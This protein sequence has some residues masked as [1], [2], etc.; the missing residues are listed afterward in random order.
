MTPPATLR[1]KA[2]FFAFRCVA[3]ALS[4]LPAPTAAALC[5]GL[6]AAVCALPPKWTRRD[7]ARK[8]LT[9]AFPDLSP[10]E[11]DD[12]VRAMWTHLFRLVTEMATFS[13][14]FRRSNMPDVLAFRNRDE[15]TRA[16]NSGRPV[17]M[18]SG[19]FGNWEASA[20]A[21]EAFGI[22]LS[23]VA[24]DLDNPLIHGWFAERRRAGGGRLISK[25]GG[26]GEVTEVLA[27]RGIVGLLGDQDAGSRGL[28][29]PFFGKD[30]STFKSI[31][32]LAI[33]YD[34]LVLIGFARRLPDDFRRN[35][36]V[37]FEIG[38]E[39][40]FDPRDFTEGSAVK[41][42]TAAYTAGIERLVRRSPEQYFWVHRRWKSKPRPRGRKARER[43]AA[44]ERERQAGDGADGASARRAVA[45]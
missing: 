4:A 15:T 17:I 42:L 18:L 41:D 9:I 7:V 34:A 10:A 26:G 37:R 19:H 25:K 11:I 22:P 24:R 5:R 14:K 21:F 23:V 40:V 20:Q 28:F 43:A 45:A 29:V 30:A 32:L 39:A 8:N 31:A 2:E 27:A 3:A 6:A 13:R 35:R 36:W 12:R 33:E 44:L 38:T 1:Q 16:L